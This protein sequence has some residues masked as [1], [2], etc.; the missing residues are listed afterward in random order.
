MLQI[1]VAIAAVMIVICRVSVRGKESSLN[2][3]GEAEGLHDV[4][5]KTSTSHHS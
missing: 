2:T 3:A 1:N 4:V 5:E